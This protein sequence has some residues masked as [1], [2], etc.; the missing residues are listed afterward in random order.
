MSLLCCSK[1]TFAFFHET[2]VL[3]RE[4]LYAT[5]TFIDKNN[6]TLKTGNNITVFYTWSPSF[7]EEHMN[8]VLRL[9]FGP[10]R[11]IAKVDEQTAI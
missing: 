7:S 1:Y 9:V 11:D 10:E 4:K 6:K 5:A 3:K 2:T 8:G